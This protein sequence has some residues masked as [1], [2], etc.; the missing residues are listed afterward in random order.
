[1]GVRAWE[2]GIRGD[3]QG[4]RVRANL[5]ALDRTYS[6]QKPS[7]ASNSRHTRSHINPH[8]IWQG[9]GDKEG[10]LRSDGSMVN[11]EGSLDLKR[12][13]RSC[14]ARSW[15]GRARG[16]AVAREEILHG[17]ASVPPVVW[18]GGA[19]RRQRAMRQSWNLVEA[20]SVAARASPDASAPTH[21]PSLVSPSASAQRVSFRRS[22]STHVARPGSGAHVFHVSAQHAPPRSYVAC[23]IRPLDHPC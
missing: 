15:R 8:V 13:K 21:Q 5:H 23:V 9:A 20:S 2:L 3:W 14:L 17:R 12:P 22:V 1:M 18:I 4:T 6:R 10:L 19:V 16:R 7:H 11:R